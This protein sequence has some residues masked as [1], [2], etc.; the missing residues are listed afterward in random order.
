MQKTGYPVISNI[1]FDA[2]IK[3]GQD[4][5]SIYLYMARNHWQRNEY[6]EVIKA[7][8]NAG[9][10]TLDNPQMIAMHAEA[11]KQLGKMHVA[12]RILDQGIELHPG[13]SK[14]FRQKFYYLLDMGLYKAA[15]GYINQYL[16]AE[17]YS[18]NEYVAVAYT[19]RENKRYDLAERLLEEGAI[20]YPEESRIHELL[21]QLYID[22]YKYL[23]AALVLD[24]ASLKSSKFSH[25]AAALYLKAN[26]PVRSMQIN[27][28]IPNQ[29]DKF[30]QRI[31]I[32][33]DLD[34][35]E[36]MVAKEDVLLRYDL[37]T[38]QNITY[39]LG[40]AFLQNR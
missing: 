5:K 39:A 15:E 6:P 25:R 10:A 16:Q 26:D 12:W 8:K 28:R 9:Q 14:F 34:D 7:L 35:Y 29:V 4:K 22:Q 19:L 13:Y 21:S 40:F 23:E 1:F 3:R 18:A 24:W 38:D 17:K 32:D 27:R 20:K 30:R 37:L 11:N 31:S 2:A 36:S 33:I